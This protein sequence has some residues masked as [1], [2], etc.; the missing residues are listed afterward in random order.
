[1][2][3]ESRR[4]DREGEIDRYREIMCMFRGEIERGN[5]KEINT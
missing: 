2:R 5:N 4:E 1:M 3:E